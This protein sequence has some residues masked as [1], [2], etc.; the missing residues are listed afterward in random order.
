MTRAIVLAAAIATLVAGAAP[1]QAQPRGAAPPPGDYFQ[2]CRN[3]STVGYGPNA[4]MTAECRD[5]DGRWRTTSLRFAGCDRI[6]NRD[7]QLSCRP[8]A[9]YPPPRPGFPGPGPGGPPFGRSS[10][11]LF[12]GPDFTGRPFPADREFTNLPREF[13]DR[14]MSLRIDGRRPWQVC[15]DSDFRGRCQVFDRD[16][17]DLS[18]FG[19]GANVSS[20]RPVR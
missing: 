8:G 14:A 16:V 11:T 6:E 13:N 1:L 12:S 10:I 15:S 18:R 9:G 20:L 2:T 3:V 5:R 17:S 7:G 19:L 4:T